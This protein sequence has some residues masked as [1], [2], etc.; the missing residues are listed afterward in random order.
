MRIAIIGGGASGLCCA[1]SA[2][3][4]AKKTGTKAEIVIYEAKV[5]VQPVVYAVQLGNLG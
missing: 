5:L 3:E 1:V 2:A 4:K